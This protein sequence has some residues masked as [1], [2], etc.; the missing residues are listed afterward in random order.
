M[1]SGHNNLLNFL[2]PYTGTH[3]VSLIPKKAKRGKPC[4]SSGF[5]RTLNSTATTSFRNR[6]VLNE[7]T[8]SAPIHNMRI[9]SSSPSRC[10]KQLQTSNEIRKF[11]WISRSLHYL[12][13]P[14]VNYVSGK[15]CEILKS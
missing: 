6:L 7:I 5:S 3:I 4:L 11:D 15:L 10:Q 13:I 1:I 12:F 9:I 14:S 8:G 2:F